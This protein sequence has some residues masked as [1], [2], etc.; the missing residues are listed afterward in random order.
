MKRRRALALTLLELVVSFSLLAMI[1]TVVLE[2][3]PG[4]LISL[5]HSQSRFAAA[6]V[7]QNQVNYICSRSF[8]SNSVGTSRD[9]TDEVLDKMTYHVH[10]D[11]LAVAGQDPATIRLVRITVSWYEKNQTLQVVRERQISQGIGG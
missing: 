6:N 7:A 2:L 1:I 9:L 5:H 3:L 10:L 8:G 4:S 11:V